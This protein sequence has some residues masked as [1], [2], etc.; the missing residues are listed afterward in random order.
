MRVKIRWW[1][2]DAKVLEVLDE[3]VIKLYNYN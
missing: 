2:I 1:T 3:I